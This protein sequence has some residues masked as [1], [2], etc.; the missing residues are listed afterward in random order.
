[1]GPDLQKPY[2]L[3]YCLH[4]HARMHTATHT[5]FA[6]ENVDLDSWINY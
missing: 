1:M 6:L 2:M 5:H 3:P 4:T